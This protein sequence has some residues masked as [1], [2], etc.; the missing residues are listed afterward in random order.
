M[1]DDDIY[2]FT[3]WCVFTLLLVC[4]TAVYSRGG[5]EIFGAQLRRFFLSFDGVLLFPFAVQVDGGDAHPLNSS[6]T[7]PQTGG[8][9][10]IFPRGAS[11]FVFCSVTRRGTLLL[12]MHALQRCLG[13]GRSSF[14]RTQ[15]SGFL[16]VKQD[17]MGSTLQ[18]QL[19]AFHIHYC[20]HLHRRNS[21]ENKPS[22]LGST[23]EVLLPSDLSGVSL[24]EIDLSI[25]GRMCFGL[26]PMVRAH[27]FDGSG[28]SAV[29]DRAKQ[30]IARGPRKYP[31]GNR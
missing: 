9:G 5:S 6:N 28:N 14:P 8:G 11:L 7:W 24:D 30:E 10:D 29:S 19:R 21:R 17:L 27:E 31:S 16:L 3:T 4:K 18:R 1:M 12:Y 2:L 25:V 23:C 26:Q 13:G 20:P 22:Y 15:S